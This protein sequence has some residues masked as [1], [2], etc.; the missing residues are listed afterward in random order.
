MTEKEEKYKKSTRREFLK[1]GAR[2]V[3][4]GAAYGA[5]GR[6]VGTGYEI[7][8]NNVAKYV[9]E[10]V[11]DAYGFVKEK[12]SDV[13]D[14]IQGKNEVKPKSKKKEPEEVSRRGFF[15]SLFNY[16]HKHPVL[17]GTAFGATYGTGKS[18]LKNYEN[19]KN[20]LRIAGEKLDR[21][22]S[23]ESI[24][25]LTREIQDLKRLIL[26]QKG[27]GKSL[28]QRTGGGTLLVIGFSILIVSIILNSW[29]LTG[30]AI[31]G[32]KKGIFSV[33]VFLFII[34]L[35]FIFIGFKRNNR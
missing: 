7:G 15:G 13:V 20:K 26:E 23:Q 14:Y 28:E 24:E 32:Y 22:K 35:I 1:Y 29:D 27:E 9:T 18:V 16:F 6:I 17:T 25:K 5:M 33:D 4:R 21:A 8:K 34:S 10:P 19:Y 3:G 30:Y 12:A 31:L 2:A 11:G